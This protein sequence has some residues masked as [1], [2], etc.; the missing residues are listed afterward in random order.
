MLEDIIKMAQGSINKANEQ[1]VA[2][3]IHRWKFCVALAADGWKAIE[4]KKAPK[5]DIII[6]WAKEGKSN[7]EIVL[8]FT[9]QRLWLD[10]M[11]KKER[12]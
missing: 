7:V 11:Q 5:D 10:Y 3:R 6:I 2:K 4:T 9:E 1:R 8:N 12:E